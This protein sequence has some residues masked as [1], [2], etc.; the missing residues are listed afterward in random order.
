MA[1]DT[2][3]TMRGTGSRSALRRSRVEAGDRLEL[4]LLSSFRVLRTGVPLNG[5]LTGKPRQFLKLLASS[6]RRHVPKD[7]LIEM[8]W[9]AGHPGA[10]ATSLKVVAHKLRTALEPEKM[11]GD[12]GRW[13]AASNGTYSLN[14]E[15]PIWIDVDEF[16]ACWRRGRTLLAEGR[17]AEARLEFARADDLY[18]G[19][20]LEED[21]YEDW[22]IV[23]REELK[24]I[25]LDVLQKLAEIAEHDHNHA[26]V[27]RYCHKIVLADPCREDGYRMLMRS[28]GALNQIARAGAW[29]AVCRA[30]LAREVGVPP[31]S[32][33]V[34]AFE[35]LFGQAAS[36]AHYAEP[37]NPGH[38]PPL[39][40]V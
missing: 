27:I 8:L 29:Y 39:T 4:Y 22:T 10:G 9:P 15:A 37:G 19:E 2:R 40:S 26:D 17:S 13:I 11:T 23:P 21:L 1:L 16:R 33:T 25:H 3:N 36:P 28:H 5:H 6:G 14:A 7:A 35:S 24:D 20:Y 30:T 34:Q 31:T 38:A 32:D 12:P 18:S